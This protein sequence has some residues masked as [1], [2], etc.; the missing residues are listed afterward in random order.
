MSVT[1]HFVP[2]TL[3][4]V[5][6]VCV[7]RVRLRR[8]NSVWSTSN[9]TSQYQVLS[10]RSVDRIQKIGAHRSCC[11]PMDAIRET[12]SVITTSESTAGGPVDSG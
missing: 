5:D 7:S 10:A 2:H 9:R 1:G 3:G 12:F 4:I 11:E 8:L 6:A